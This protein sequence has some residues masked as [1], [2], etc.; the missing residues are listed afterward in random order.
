MRQPGQ[1]CAAAAAAEAL[2]IQ[3]TPATRMVCGA[4]IRKFIASSRGSTTPPR[5]G[6]KP[7]RRGTTQRCQAEAQMAKSFAMIWLP[8]EQMAHACAIGPD[9][10]R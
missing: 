7:E 1:R 3:N 5:Q 2:P 9:S 6:L 8:G 10:V 4:E